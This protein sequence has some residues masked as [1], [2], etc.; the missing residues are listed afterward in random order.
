MYVQS[1]I[2]EKSLKKN[3]RVLLGSTDVD[4]QLNIHP[5]IDTLTYMRS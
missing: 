1:I 2:L 3:I 5:D 4:I